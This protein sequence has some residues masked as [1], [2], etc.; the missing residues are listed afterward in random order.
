[1]TKNIKI[2]GAREN[3]LKNFNLT[4]PHEKLVVI[5]G[6]SGSGKSSL[7]FG[8]IYSEGQR[9]YVESMSS[10][11]RQFLHTGKK[12]DVDKIEG[13]WP[14]I[15]IDQK[16]TSRN[17]RST[18]GT[19]TEILDYL[20][21]LYASVGKPY[22]PVTNLLIK[23]QP[24]SEV[25]DLIMEKENVNIYILAPIAKEEKGEFK[26]ELFELKK[27]GFERVLIDGFVYDLN[28]SENLH[29]E[30]NKKHDIEIIID[31]ITITQAN[32]DRITNSVTTAF[33]EGDGICFAAIVTD[34]NEP[35]KEKIVFSQ[36][37]ACPVSGFQIPEIEPKMLSFNNPIGACETC[38]GLGIEYYFDENKIVPDESISILAGAIKP[39][40][41]SASAIKNCTN[42]LKPIIDKFKL[43][44]SAPFSNIPINVKKIIFSGTKDE[45]ILGSQGKNFAGIIKSLE[46]RCDS[47]DLDA[48]EFL[49]EYKSNRKCHKCNGYRLKSEMLCI[50][51]N[52]LHIGQVQEIPVVN[53]HTWFDNLIETLSEQD[54]VLAKTL[55][56]E[57]KSRLS[58]LIEVGLG[59]IT[60]SRTA[61]TL[62][63]GESQRIRLASQIG[64]GLSGVIYVL[65]EPSIGLHPR[66]TRK[67]INI[68]QKLVKQGNSVIVVEHDIETINAAEHII[69]I[70]REAGINGGTICGHGT[71][72][73]IM[74]IENSLTSDYLNGRRSINIIKGER[75]DS[76]KFIKLIGAC[77]NNLKNVD[78]EI[79]LGKFI[80][81]TGVSGGGKSTLIMQT[82][83]RAI[84]KHFNKESKEIPGKY[85]KITGLE[86]IDK[87]IDIDQSPIG[88]TPR[89][90]I[91][92]YTGIFNYIRDIYAG[93]P[94]SQSRGYGIGKFS[95]NVK[96]G[97]CEACEGGGYIKQEMYFMAEIFVKCEVCDGKR[98]NKEILE[99]KYKNKSIYDVLELTIDDALGFFEN[100]SHIYEKLVRLKEVGLGYLKIGQSATTLSGGE[101]QRIKLAKELARKSTGKTIYI[102]DEP[103]TGLHIHDTAKL[104]EVLHKLVDIGNTVIVIEHNVE[105]VKTSDHIVDI[106][107]EGGDAG[108]LI[109]A[110]GTIQDIINNKKSVTGKFL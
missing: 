73:D 65:D 56:V 109:V 108:G 86:H 110:T 80:S 87:I 39:W 23:S 57:I 77:E 19:M 98:Y 89:S 50:K 88:R 93:L 52:N 58:F 51:I 34:K 43:D 4:I 82:L 27:Q 72:K 79:P 49:S 10:Y 104:L 62:S 14:A 84:N 63:G 41:H 6:L 9:K 71:L 11:V 25:V 28:N 95:F 99:I 59:Y 35:I 61:N 107:P 8:I 24:I 22:S 102:L 97:R 55:I 12:A 103:T 64:S 33:E 78:L 36:K 46:T 37:Y 32:R 100:I 75:K 2:Y 3:N 60:L 68:L 83:Y 13:L 17:P 42:Y 15:A 20:R 26:K 92:T 47:L 85:K 44:T 54:Q 45:T 31:R 70:G 5:T 69:D 53:L 96:G 29:L 66:D 21:L 7:A 67:L 81:I 40:A 1:M 18:V 94:I 16:T 106:G 91:A 90:N 105:V 74:K 101:A 76:N 30:K 38:S 48:K